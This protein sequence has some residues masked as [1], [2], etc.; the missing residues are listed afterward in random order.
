MNGTG[1]TENGGRR[2]PIAKNR[3]PKTKILVLTH[4]FPTKHNPIAGIFILNQLE[5]LKKFCDIKVIYPYPYVPRI[6]IFNPYRRFSEVPFKETVS[7]IEVCHPKYFMIP[8]A[9]LRTKLLHFYLAVE[10]FFSYLSSKRL[11][12]RIVK[13]W[14]PNII[15]MHGSFSEGQLS[16]MLKKKYH[17]PLLI[18]VYGEDITRYTKQFPSSNLIKFSLNNADAIICQSNFLKEE[19][20]RAGIHGKRFHIIPMGFHIGNF[21]PRDKA[22]SRKMLDLPIEK[23]IILFVGHLIERKGVKY[24]IQAVKSVVGKHKD[25]LC[26]IVGKGELESSLKGMASELKLN[27]YVKFLGLKTNEEVS[28]YMNAC[29]V[30]VLPSLNEGLPV[31]LCEALACGKPVV[32]TNVAGTPEIVNNDVG[33]LVKPKDAEDLAEKIEFALS[34]KWDKKKILERASNFSTAAS[35]KKLVKVYDDFLKQ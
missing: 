31:V 24:L 13:D 20:E 5:Q 4:S 17:K 19:I 10:S 33:F 23:K 16:V 29:D 2:K 8:R 11:A 34:K 27:D 14:N 32:A 21:R 6:R 26:L 35:A 18:T 7:G 30:F 28:C 22:K 25:T 15:H 9:L 3:M 12:V 1:A